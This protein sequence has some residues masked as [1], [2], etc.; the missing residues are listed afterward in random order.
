MFIEDKKDYRRWLKGLRIGSVVAV[1]YDGKEGRA[2][3]GI[4]ERV[5][6]KGTVWVRFSTKGRELCIR[7]IRGQGWDTSDEQIGIMRML[8][9]RGD[10]YS[11]RRPEVLRWNNAQ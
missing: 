5:P 7:F 8:G 3:A 10:F 2:R 11:I 4:V 9:A 1:C 6:G